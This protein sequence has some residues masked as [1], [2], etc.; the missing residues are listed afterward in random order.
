MGKQ[1]R[2]LVEDGDLAD[3]PRLGILATYFCQV[4]GKEI[5]HQ[6]ARRATEEIKAV[7]K[8]RNHDDE[9][10]KSNEHILALKKR[11]NIKPIRSNLSY[12]ERKNMK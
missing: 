12:F 7:L 4:I 9:E 10:L 6:Q 11:L 2:E 5:A 1:L 8:V 3:R